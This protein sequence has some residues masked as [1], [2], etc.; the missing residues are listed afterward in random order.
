MKSFKIIKLLFLMGIGVFSHIQM[1]G[2]TEEPKYMYILLKNGSYKC[3]E[4]SHGLGFYNDGDPA[5]NKYGELV[6]DAETDKHRS[7]MKALYRFPLSEVDSIV[8]TPIPLKIT[9]NFDV[10]VEVYS[11][12][13]DENDSVDIY[14]LNVYGFYADEIYRGPEIVHQGFGLN[15]YQD[16]YQYLEEEE[17]TERLGWVKTYIYA[18]RKPTMKEFVDKIK[19]EPGA[20]YYFY[21][22]GR[23]TRYRKD[24]TGNY[25][26][27]ETGAKVVDT[28][29][30]VRTDTFALTFPA[31]ILDWLRKHP[32]EAYH[33]DV[34]PV[35]KSSA[36]NKGREC[37]PFREQEEVLEEE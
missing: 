20:T 35:S 26:Y 22:E 27:K 31:D 1:H 16:P 8:F 29:Q 12:I 7:H 23:E 9:P 37:L 21:L 19:V 10:R 36:L 14:G 28:I 6:I 3:M 34:V 15:H 17:R 33:I 2:Q 4:I 13:I 30:K 11:Y 24:C 5:I 32:E 25:V 18:S